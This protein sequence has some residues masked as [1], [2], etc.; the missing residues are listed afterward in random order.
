MSDFKCDCSNYCAGDETEIYRDKIC[1]ARRNY[2]CCECGEVVRAGDKHESVWL[3]C[4]GKWEG[5]RTCLP[6]FRVR[7]EFCPNGWCL[8]GLRE[9]LQDCINLDYLAIPTEN[10]DIPICGEIPNAN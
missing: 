8:G 10:L 2:R 9:Q 7:S 5:Y 3:L 1:V 4:D 6:C